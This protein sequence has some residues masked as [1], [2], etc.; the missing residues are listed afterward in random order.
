MPE[1]EPP[2]RPSYWFPAKTF[3]FGWGPPNCWQGWAVLAAFVATILA[4]APL[5]DRHLAAYLIIVLGASG[6]LLAI[7]WKKGE[8]AC[9]RWGGD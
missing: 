1:T 8:P 6:L 3:G 4:A 7:C 2:Q 5:A 9:W